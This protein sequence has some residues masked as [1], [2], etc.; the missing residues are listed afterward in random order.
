MLS[1]LPVWCAFKRTYRIHRFRIYSSDF[2]KS[3][4][5][6]IVVL[7]LKCRLCNLAGS[8]HVESGG[9]QC[10]ACGFRGEDNL[11]HYS[12]WSCGTIGPC[13]RPFDPETLNPKS[14][15][16][17]AERPVRPRRANAANGGPCAP[18]RLRVLSQELDGNAAGDGTR[19]LPSLDHYRRLKDEDPIIPFSEAPIISKWG[20]ISRAARAGY[21]TADP[22]QATGCKGGASTTAI[23]FKGASRPPSAKAEAPAERRCVLLLLCV[24]QITTL[25]WTTATTGGA[26]EDPTP[27]ATPV[28][29]RGTACSRSRSRSRRRL[30]A[31]S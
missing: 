13:L 25:T 26:P 15:P 31:S 4:K 20:A 11:A 5:Y 29:W 27:P 6:S 2:S 3:Y 28:S 9:G 17:C 18:S 21:H 22:I 8:Q 30:S 10:A 19:W 24:W 23:T 16:S 1:P 12:P 14:A 7:P